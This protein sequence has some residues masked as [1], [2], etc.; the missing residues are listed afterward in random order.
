VNSTCSRARESADQAP[1]RNSRLEVDVLWV[2]RDGKTPFDLEYN[3]QQ[4][5]RI[6]QSQI[7]ELGRAIDAAVR[8]LLLRV[9]TSG[10]P[11]W[12]CG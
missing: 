10:S 6:D 4:I 11:E 1:Q 7:E 2:E 8:K 9:S 5:L 12:C 3:V